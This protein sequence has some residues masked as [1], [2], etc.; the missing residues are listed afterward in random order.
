MTAMFENVGWLQRHLLLLDPEGFILNFTLS[1]YC[2]LNSLCW[3]SPDRAMASCTDANSRE[4]YKLV[5][6]RRGQE[7]GRIFLW[8]S[9]ITSVLCVIYLV[10]FCRFFFFF[11]FVCV[12]RLPNPLP[13]LSWWTLQKSSQC[14]EYVKGSAPFLL[15]FLFNNA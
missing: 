12:G 4:K 5:G 9:C 15:N 11:V 2:M 10:D 3:G 1:A 6:N 8:N 7:R 13:A 14:S